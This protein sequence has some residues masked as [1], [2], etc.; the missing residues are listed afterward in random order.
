MVNL[1]FAVAFGSLL[2]LLFGYLFSLRTL[3]KR[4]MR[5][6]FE[7]TNRLKMRHFNAA[8]A[9]PFS[10]TILKISPAF[11]K[12]YSQANDAEVYKLEQVSGIG[13]GRALEFLIKDYAKFE[14]P[15]RSEE[16]ERCALGKCIKDHISDEYIRNSGELAVWLRNDETHYVRKF[17]QQDVQS[18]KKLIHSIVRL[19]EN[20]AERNRINQDS[21]RIRDSMTGATS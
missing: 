4:T 19:I 7:R 17:A 5:D 1:I 8:V 15:D 9:P 14:H 16:I 10:Q 3:T 12:I 11:C 2:G 21:Q 6:E 18:L 20:A 13:Y